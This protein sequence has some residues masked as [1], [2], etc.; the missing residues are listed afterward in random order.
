[1]LKEQIWDKISKLKSE[2]YLNVS[3]EENI[4][5]LER[6]DKLEEQVIELGLEQEVFD[7]LPTWMQ[8]LGQDFLYDV[9]R[10]HDLKNY[11]SDKGLSSD[12]LKFVEII[13]Q[14]YDI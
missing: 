12:G 11:W 13:K 6:L 8:D 4:K 10:L 5:Q 3:K 7:S 2:D 14:K 9:Q 1:M